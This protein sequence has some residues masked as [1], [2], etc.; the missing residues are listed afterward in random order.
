M[1]NFQ[2][3]NLGNIA[4]NLVNS[5][6]SAAQSARDYK[7]DPV[8][9]AQAT[10]MGK[11][12]LWNVVRA[13]IALIFA[14]ILFGGLLAWTG[15]HR[16][17]GVMAWIVIS[18]LVIARNIRKSIKATRAVTQGFGMPPVG[19]YK[20]GNSTTGPRGPQYTYDVTGPYTARS[21]AQN[22]PPKKMLKSKKNRRILMPDGTWLEI[23]E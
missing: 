13:V 14:V 19:A 15:G 12:M 6:N 5:F 16:Y 21:G 23:M 9:M 3:N 11:V 2:R 18:I 17:W 7:P 8:K 4:N 10:A 22:S 20:P 1:S